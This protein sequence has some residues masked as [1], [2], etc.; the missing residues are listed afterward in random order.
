MK[1]K[2]GYVIRVDEKDVWEG[3]NPKR[4]FDEIKRR[5][6]DKRVSIAWKTR[7]KVLAFP[8]QGGDF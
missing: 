4:K 1:E 3:R 7:E 5:N 6:P 8:N 2:F